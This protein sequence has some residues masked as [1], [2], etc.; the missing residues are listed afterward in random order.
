MGIHLVLGA[1]GS[2]GLA[3]TKLRKPHLT[4][5]PTEYNNCELKH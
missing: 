2:C 5:D 3:Q 1:E 4:L